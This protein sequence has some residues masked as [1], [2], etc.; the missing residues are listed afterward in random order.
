[1]KSKRLWLILALTG[2]LTFAIILILRLTVQQHSSVSQSTADY[3]NSHEEDPF[4]KGRDFL[5]SGRFKEAE[6]EF[7]M[8]LRNDPYHV[9]ALS[10]LGTLYYRM[11]DI[12]RAKQ[13]WNE[14]LKLS[15]N[16]PIISGLL[17]KVDN[18]ENTIEET[19]SWQSH[20]EK[21]EDLY[22][23]GDYKQA[24]KE[25]KQAVRIKNDDPKIYF[26]LGAAYL[27]NG[28]R[29]EAIK[30]WEKALKLDPEDKMIRELLYKAKNPET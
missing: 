8:A 19:D 15:P 24:L 12:N 21:G 11:G 23:R 25:L 30:V 26:V 4:L 22:S 2:T 13:Y 6:Q 7:K 20:F 1:M 10:A 5:Y 16:D 28:K 3:V 17:E 27:K 14:A 9:K 18:S 29:A